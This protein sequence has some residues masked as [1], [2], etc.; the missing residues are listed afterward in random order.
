MWPYIVANYD[1]LGMLTLVHRIA[2]QWVWWPSQ[3]NAAAITDHIVRI[4]D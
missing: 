4:W 1:I 3:K 2:A